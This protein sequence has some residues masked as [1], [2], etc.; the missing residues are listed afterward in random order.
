MSDNYVLEFAIYHV[1]YARQITF[2]DDKA[3]FSSPLLDHLTDCTERA[4][5]DY[6]WTEVFNGLRSQVA[7]SVSNYILGYS[8]NIL[9]NYIA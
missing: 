3:V 7:N 8:S 6:A 1:A 2:S 4:V 5:S 9:K